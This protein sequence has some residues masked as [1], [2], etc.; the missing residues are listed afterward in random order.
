MIIVLPGFDP[1]ID[2]LVETVLDY[3]ALLLFERY[4]CVLGE[5]FYELVLEVA[6]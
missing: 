4:A 2:G 1:F 5:Q 6:V 3:S